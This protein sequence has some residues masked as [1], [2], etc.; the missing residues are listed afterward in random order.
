MPRLPLRHKTQRLLRL[1]Q[2]RLRRHRRR[3]RALLL[4]LVHEP[5]GALVVDAEHLTIISFVLSFLKIHQTV[6]P[7][8]AQSPCVGETAAPP[9]F[10]VSSTCRW[11]AHSPP[12]PGTTQLTVKSVL[13]CPHW[14]Y[15]HRMCVIARDWAA[16]VSAQAAEDCHFCGDSTS[17]HTVLPWW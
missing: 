17:M 15:R 11:Q 4:A 8:R 12:T 2:P 5:S 1:L 13:S 16:H 3:L 10:L 14:P 6:V 9:S 7:P